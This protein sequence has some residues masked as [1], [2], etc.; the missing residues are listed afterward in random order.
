MTV[1]QIQEAIAALLHRAL[2]CDEPERLRRNMTRRL[3]RNELARFYYWKSR[4]RLAP[5]RIQHR[6]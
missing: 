4:N 6:E 1:P 2:Y 3:E 5:L